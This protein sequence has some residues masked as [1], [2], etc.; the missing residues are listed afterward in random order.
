MFAVTCMRVCHRWP[1]WDYACLYFVIFIYLTCTLLLCYNHFHQ[2][3]TPSN[4]VVFLEHFFFFSNQFR[5]FMASLSGIYWKHR[6]EK[7][8]G[9]LKL[10]QVLCPGKQNRWGASSQ[11]KNLRLQWLCQP[12]NGFTKTCICEHILDHSLLIPS[13]QWFWADHTAELSKDRASGECLHPTTRPRIRSW[14][15]A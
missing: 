9:I 4:Q 15:T 3:S 2:R 6:R 12:P 1:H 10:C 14:K 8:T 5:V 7:H 11:H 13:F